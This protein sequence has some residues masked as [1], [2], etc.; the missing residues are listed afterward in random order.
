[1]HLT[2][3]IFAFLTLCL[4]VAAIILTAKT[5]DRQNEWNNR[6]E[7]ARLAYQQEV[8]K[9]PD[10]RK[11]VLQLR[12]D[13]TLS[14]LDWGRHWDRVQVSPRNLQQG[15]ITIGIGRNGNNGLARQ[16]DAGE[17]FPLLYGFQTLED[18][19]VKYVGEFRVT[20]IDATQA[21]LQLGRTPRD[22]ETATW[23]T[24]VPWRFRDALPSAKRAQIGE[25]LLELTLFEQRLKDRQLN[26]A[27]Q[28]KSVQSARALLE[29]RLKEL[30]GDPELPEEAGEERRL[31]L[32]EAINQAESRRDEALAEVQQLRVELHDLYALFEDLL[33]VNR[34]LEQE[35][36]KRS[37]VAE[38]TEV[39][40]NRDENATK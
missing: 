31:G 34:A 40:A 25:L 32:V 27:T 12:N 1:M 6:V 5:L 14:R 16:T 7:K 35:L 37:G 28:Q 13:L 11:Q 22:G 24:S 23:N 38:D 10:A 9:L 21:A 20:Q 36:S 29:D 17:Q 4:S 15:Q 3:K 18:G 33:A 30:N 26:L 39:S 19:S 8:A 2:G